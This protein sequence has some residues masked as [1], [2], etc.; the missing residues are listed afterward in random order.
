VTARHGT[1]TGADIAWAVG[2]VL[3]GLLGRWVER[4]ITGAPTRDQAVRAAGRI[5][6]S[7]GTLG[8]EGLVAG[9]PFAPPGA[10]AVHH[11]GHRGLI[12]VAELVDAVRGGHRWQ[13]A[14][15]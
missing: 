1:L 14:L 8:P 4:Q 11:D 12:T 13:E 9:Q 3:D 15:F 7:S 5:L 2:I 10:L 6:A